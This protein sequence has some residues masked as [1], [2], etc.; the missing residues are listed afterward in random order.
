MTRTHHH[1]P[2]AFRVVAVSAALVAL[3]AV[4][5]ASGSASPKDELRE[6]RQARRSAESQLTTAQ[7]QLSSIQTELAAALLKLE[8]ATGRLEEVTANLQAT[9][10]E[11]DAAES[12][13]RR[14]QVRLNERAAEVFMEG[15]AS[16][17]G[18]YLGA[19]SLS[20][21]SDRIEYVD[22]V[23][24][25]DADLAQEVLNLRN[26]L[27]AT[28]AR[29]EKLQ[30]EARRRQSDA[31]A[32]QADVEAKL[33]AQEAALDQVRSE[34]TDAKADVKSA[35]KAYQKWLASTSYGGHSSVAMPAGWSKVFEA[36]PVDQPRGF[37]D[38]FGAPRYVGGYHLHKGV[39][40]VAPLGTVVRAT[41]DGMASDATN[42]YGGT[43]VYVTGRYGSTYN[44]HLTSIAKLGP[45]QAGDVIGY[46]G[47][48]GLAGGE[49]NHNHF[50]F[51]PNV[52]PSN[53]P[54]SYYG[55]SIIDDA[56]NPYPLLVA[57]CG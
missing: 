36:C 44:A 16:D 24:Q 56:I 27:L 15:P 19:T 17:V 57:A 42:T 2:V 9:R 45:V 51:R 53:W 34:F 38:G 40:I 20:D 55:Y 39:D 32:L 6:A 7:G 50:E 46:V 13:F 52:M 37:G 25:G 29:L 8:D 47:S 43:A 28:E 4:A 14:I 31:Q 22:V 35:E 21:L 1:F 49:T 5:A 33:Q 23:Q 3:I 41:F 48:T 10:Q 26:E 30:S 11:R 18:F 54:A 12:R